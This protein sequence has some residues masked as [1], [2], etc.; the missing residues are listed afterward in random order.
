MATIVKIETRRTAYSAEDAAERTL[1][2]KD[3]K[4]MLDGFDDDSPVVFSNDNG[5]TYGEVRWGCLGEVESKDEEDEEEEET[6]EDAI[7]GGDAR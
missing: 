7:I 2:V 3:L 4:E 5:Y 6:D 1:T